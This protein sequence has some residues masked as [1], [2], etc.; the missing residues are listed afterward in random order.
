MPITLLSCD[1]AKAATGFPGSSRTLRRFVEEE[2]IAVRVM[3]RV[4]VD[5]DMLA[6]RLRPGAVR[7]VGKEAMAA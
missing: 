4:Y 2:R 3:G 1:A 6:A 7:T 5:P